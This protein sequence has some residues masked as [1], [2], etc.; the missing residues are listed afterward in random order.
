LGG[1]IGAAVASAK[2]KSPSAGPVAGWYWTCLAL[3]AGA[4]VIW[5]A[6]QGDGGMGIGIIGLLLLLPLVQLIAS[7]LTL[8]SIG[9]G[10]EVFP[11]K[12]ASLRTLGIITLYS[13][14]GALAGA[15]AMMFGLGMFG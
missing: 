1:L 15:I 11:N 9:I 12:N 13:F 14:L 5:G 2:D 6:S 10:G 7:V 3:L 4:G 8:I